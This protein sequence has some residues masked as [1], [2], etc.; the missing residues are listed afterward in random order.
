MLDWLRVREFVY[1]PPG[2]TLSRFYFQQREKHW[3]TF[4]TAGYIFFALLPA[5]KVK[6]LRTSTMSINQLPRNGIST[7]YWYVGNSSQESYILSMTYLQKLY[8]YSGDIVEMPW[9]CYRN[10]LEMFRS[11][12][13]KLIISCY[14]NGWLEQSRNERGGFL[15]LTLVPSVVGGGWRHAWW[16][17]LRLCLFVFVFFVFVFLGRCIFICCI[18]W[19]CIFGTHWLCPAVYMSLSLCTVFLGGLI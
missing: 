15:A 11:M 16:R 6:I 12:H 14:R 2:K 19:I 18:F 9:R 4:L 10:T 5:D 13:L 8:K 3:I 7:S 1:C 17:C